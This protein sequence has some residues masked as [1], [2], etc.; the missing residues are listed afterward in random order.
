M[1]PQPASALQSQASAP[2]NF[3]SWIGVPAIL[4]TSVGELCV[5]LRGIVLRES[6]SALRFR[7]GEGWDV[8]IFKSMVLGIE[9]DCWNAIT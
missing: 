6:D 1:T 7:M 5:P 8:D 2:Q 3:E 9:Q 4:H